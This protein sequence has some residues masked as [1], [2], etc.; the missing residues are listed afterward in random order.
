MCSGI[1]LSKILLINSECPYTPPPSPEDI[2]RR[3]SVGDTGDDTGDD[4]L[5]H[6]KVLLVDKKCPEYATTHKKVSTCARRS[7]VSIYILIFANYPLY[8][9]Q[10]H[11]E[12]RNNM[13]DVN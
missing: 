1:Y 8:K 4:I 11:S 7:D 12:S 6:I 2:S 9:N 5:V 3:S 10:K 13:A